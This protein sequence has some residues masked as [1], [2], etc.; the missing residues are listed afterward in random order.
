MSVVSR[1]LDLLSQHCSATEMRRTYN[2]ALYMTARH[3]SV[4]VMGFLFCATD[5]DK[6]ALNKAIVL[7]CTFGHTATMLR[8]LNPLRSAFSGHGSLSK[9]LDYILNVAA[10]NGHVEVVKILIQEG[11]NIDAVSERVPWNSDHGVLVTREGELQN[12]RQ[13]A[14]QAAMSGFTDSPWMRY[15]FEETE[16]WSGNTAAREATVLLLLEQC[17]N[18]YGSVNGSDTLVDAAVKYCSATIVQ[19]KI[20]KNPSLMDSPFDRKMAFRI[21]ASREIGAAAVIKVLLHAGS[22]PTESESTHNDNEPDFKLILDQALDFFRKSPYGENWQ[23]QSRPIHDVLQDGPGAVIKLILKLSPTITVEDMRYSYLLQMSVAINDRECTDLLLQRGIDVNAQGRYY[24]TALQCAARFGNSELVQRL[25]D[26]NARVNTLSGRYGTALRAAIWGGHE[27][28]VG[29]LLDHGANVNLRPSSN[30]SKKI[31]SIPILHLALRSPKLAILRSLIAAGADVNADA[32]NQPIILSIACGLGD[33]AMVQLFLDNK[34][35]LTFTRAIY[36][37]SFKP[38]HESDSE[39]DDYLDVK[40]FDKMELC[41]EERASALHVACA[42][43]REDIVRVLLEHGANVQLE[44]EVLFRLWTPK[45]QGISPESG[46]DHY[47]ISRTPLQ[48]A[49]KAGHVSIVRLLINAGARINHCN[50]HGTALSIASREDKLEVVE[51]LLQFGSCL[52]DSSDY[53]SVLKAA[54][55]SYSLAIFEALLD[56]L[57]PSMEKRAYADTFSAAIRAE[58]NSVL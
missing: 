27:K 40:S 16:G 6:I 51:E 57:P 48:V 53:S 12:P 15:T 30:G 20:D 52:P 54:C 36:R 31:D 41:Q 17:A 42:K 2:D 14:L 44:F 13:T 19:A 38:M 10:F 11:A 37:P 24:G 3:N 1:A 32:T 18:I 47:Y 8:L 22:Y 33:L 4:K 26:L 35:N 58:N 46:L 29:I 39:S 50:P 21:A 5:M 25:L 45:E 23:Q 9:I 7:S 56:S 55:E 28:V 43:G 34:I 49:A